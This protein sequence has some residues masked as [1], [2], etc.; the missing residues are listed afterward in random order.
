VNCEESIVGTLHASIISFAQRK[1]AFLL[2][3]AQ[4]T[5]DEVRAIA[6]RRWK[7]FLFPSVL[8]TILCVVGA[9]TLPRRYESTT[10]ILVQRDETLNPL[11]SFTM[12]VAMASED[13]LRTFNEIIYS[14]TT[15]QMLIDSLGLGRAVET[16]AQRQALVKDVQ[17]NIET[18]RR[19]SNSF[20]IVYID[21]DPVRAQRG[22]SLLANLFI[23]INLEAENRRNDLT[24]QFFE[25][26]LE[27]FRQKF[28]TSQKRLLSVLK[29]RVDTV[30]TE[31]RALYTQMEELGRR[32]ADIDMR[33][34]NYQEELVLLRTFPGAMHT[35]S[36]KQALFDLQRS[37]LPNA[38][39]LRV[40][41]AKHDEFTR[42]YTIRYPELE[43]IEQQILSL[44][45]RMGI[46]VESEIAK[47]RGL[48]WDLEKQ[49][50][51]IVE[52]LKRSSVVEKA[53]Q[54]K[55]SNYNIYRQ[56]YDDMK[57]KLEQAQTTRDLAARGANQYVIL[58]PALVPTVPSKP[59]R[60]MIL[61]GGTG[62]GILIGVLAA[63]A[64][65][66]F[67]T[68]VRSPMDIERYQKPVIAFIPDAEFKE[69]ES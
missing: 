36:G 22:A 12:A 2:R 9:Y 45:E 24:V 7:L 6:R 51:R 42:R 55:E 38:S 17:H 64:A 67:D 4:F 39:D 59:N 58:D 30:P 25:R 41:L 27:E 10:T 28:E 68:A 50:S 63:V 69:L 20:T 11:V 14:R 26:K 48:R 61:L 60:R 19:G 66:L 33:L 65:E 29:G 43:K 52:E 8:V 21:T 44:L 54:D 56:L 37:D 31:S 46:A 35:D 1:G 23:R 57:L 15:T 3:P 62:L 13:P 32:I 40:L 5:I 34:K 18:D 16:E 47:Q 49:R 53:D